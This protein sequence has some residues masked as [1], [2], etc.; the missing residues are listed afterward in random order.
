[1]DECP[2]AGVDKNSLSVHKTVRI[3]IGYAAAYGLGQG[4][5][6]IYLL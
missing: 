5:F 2:V 3:G 1:M 4:V 6:I